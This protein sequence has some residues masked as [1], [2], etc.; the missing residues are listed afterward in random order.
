MSWRAAF[1]RAT[2][3]PAPSS[4][5][6]LYILSSALMKRI[7]ILLLALGSTT[8]WGQSRRYVNKLALQPELQAEYGF[9]NGDYLLLGLRGQRFTGNEGDP[10]RLGFDERQVRLGYE[11][12]WNERW[13][14]GA[15]ARVVSFTASNELIP[16]VLLR[17][18]SP[19]GPLT[20]GQRLSVERTFPD[21]H[22]Y[23]GGPGP[24]GKNFARL[25]LDLEKQFPLSALTLRPR[26]SY[27]LVSQ[28]R[29]QKEDGD[30]TIRPISYG[31][32]RGEVGV[33]FSKHI[34]LT[35]WFAFQT[36]YLYTLEQYNSMGQKVSG[37]DL[38]SIYPTLGL[39]LRFTL[40]SKAVQADRQTLPTQH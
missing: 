6:W 11:H 16:E 26:L 23:L 21:N 2:S 32:L 7:L 28:V 10:Q 33:R 15:T 13:S 9:G 1:G 8:A 20:F 30:P 18:R 19:L 17:H 34:D 39:D 31:S 40:L 4:R 24:D 37:G 12:F 35:P 3:G 14:W 5:C 36:N 25:R 27:E 38:N 29:F 22:G